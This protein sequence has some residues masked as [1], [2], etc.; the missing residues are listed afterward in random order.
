[1]IQC[2]GREKADGEFSFCLHISRCRQPKQQKERGENP[3]IES[4]AAAQA[5]SWVTAPQK[6][7]WWL[8]PQSERITS[9]GDRATHCIPNELM[10]FKYHP[11]KERVLKWLQLAVCTAAQHTVSKERAKWLCKCLPCSPPSGNFSLEFKDEAELAYTWSAW[12][13]PL[14]AIIP[15]CCGQGRFPK[16]DGKYGSVLPPGGN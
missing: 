3:A 8:L 12:N 13:E 6:Q 1:M 15:P 14:L 5:Q 7:S 9:G 11:P 10:S 2:F 16:R 4:L